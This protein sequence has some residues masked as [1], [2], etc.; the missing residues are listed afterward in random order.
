MVDVRVNGP[1]TLS[2]VP[3]TENAD[4]TELNDLAG[5]R[6]YAGERSREYDEIVE[7]ADPTASDARITL[8]SGDYFVAMTAIDLE[9][10]ESA[11]SNEVL[12][13]VP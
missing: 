8:P 6:I 7:L 13:S 1:V 2:W 10:N 5:Y 3:P 11:Y 4:G 12:R 9:G